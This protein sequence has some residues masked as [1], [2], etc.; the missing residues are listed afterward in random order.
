MHYILNC[1]HALSCIPGLVS[2]LSNR[3]RIILP[4]LPVIKVWWQTRLCLPQKNIPRP[5]YSW[6]F[7]IILIKKLWSRSSSLFYTRLQDLL[8]NL[9]QQIDS[10]IFWYLNRIP[11]WLRLWLDY[12]EIS[13]ITA[14]HSSSTWHCKFS[15]LYFFLI[16]DLCHLQW[17]EFLCLYFRGPVPEL[18]QECLLLWLVLTDTLVILC[19]L[20]VSFYINFSLISIIHVWIIF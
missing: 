3:I 1:T 19:C 13:A 15:F 5:V 8:F 10:S 17:I 18:V 16:C 9:L 6:R 20:Y 11:V 14:S 7:E 12:L 4:L 2:R